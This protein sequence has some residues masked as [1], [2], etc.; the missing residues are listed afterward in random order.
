MQ[1]MQFVKINLQDIVFDK[2]SKQ[3]GKVKYIDNPTRTAKI[4]VII[5]KD[6]KAG[7]RTTRLIEARLSNL[8][9]VEEAKKKPS[10]DPN[11]WWSLVK[12][13]HKAFNHPV[14]EKPTQMELTRATDRAVWT[15]EEALVEFI[16]ASSNSKEEFNEAYKM[17]IAG[18]DKAKVKSDAME[19]YEEG[20]PRIVAQSDALIDALYFIMGSLVEMG[21][22]PDKLMDAVQDAN[23]SKLF[24][25]ENGKKFAKYR[26]DDG[27]IL[28]SPDFFQ[29]EPELLKE[30]LRQLNK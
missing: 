14:K 12:M 15:G 26:E 30:I 7:E 1:T 9:V 21:V 16:H 5:N 19:F 29:P 17:L 4:E 11:K 13:F 27:K 24:T 3:H 6:E 28:K 22:K 10:H 25:D 8:V 18:L 2:G 20:V 23:M